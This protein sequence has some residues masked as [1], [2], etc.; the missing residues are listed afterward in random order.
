MFS[1]EKIIFEQSIRLAV[2]ENLLIEPT[3]AKQQS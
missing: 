2:F 1:N 3:T